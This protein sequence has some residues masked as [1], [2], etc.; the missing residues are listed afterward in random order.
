MAGQVYVVP[1]GN[2][3]NIGTVLTSYT[4]LTAVQKEVVDSIR[5]NG[6]FIQSFY[7]RNDGLYC[8]VYEIVVGTDSSYKMTLAITGDTYYQ[9][10]MNTGS[11]IVYAHLTLNAHDLQNPDVDSVRLTYHNLQQESTPQLTTGSNSSYGR[12]WALLPYA[13]Q[14]EAYNAIMGIAIVYPITYRLTNATTTGPI[15][16]VAGDTVTVPLTFPDGYGI[17]NPSSDAYVTCNGVLVP[18]T[19]SNGQ[20]VFTMPDPS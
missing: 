7:S 10:K 13:T 12:N 18:S 11:P 5:E 1:A 19:Y 20:L 16:A 15:E 3:A 14:E 8:E 6:L 17:V 2:I 9:Y 4:V